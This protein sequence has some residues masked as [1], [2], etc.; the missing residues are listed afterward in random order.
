MRRDELGTGTALRV[1]EALEGIEKRVLHETVEPRAT[2]IGWVGVDQARATKPLEGVRRALRA[3]A[4]AER[5]VP[6]PNRVP[7]R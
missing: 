1:E 3:H 6:C 4:C 5:Q 2:G 7:V